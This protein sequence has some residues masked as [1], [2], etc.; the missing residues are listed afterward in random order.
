MTT[1]SGT[2]VTC[3]VSRFTG[4]GAVFFLKRRVAHGEDVRVCMCL[5]VCL[6]NTLFVFLTTRVCTTKQKPLHGC[7]FVAEEA[8]VLDLLSP[9][10]SQSVFRIHL[11]ECSFPPEMGEFLL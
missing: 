7:L 4:S 6:K 2:T 11:I 1:S 8:D 10:P 3:R 9:F 5:C